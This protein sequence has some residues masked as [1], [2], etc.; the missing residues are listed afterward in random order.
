MGASPDRFLSLAEETRAIIPLGAWVLREACQK[1]THWPSHI[2]I[3]VNLSPL[4]FE[5]GH[6]IE[7][8]MSA[9]TLAGLQ[10]ERLELEVTEMTPLKD[11]AS[12]VRQLK[13]LK[14]LGIKVAMDDFGTGFS[15]LSY[16]QTRV[17]AIGDPTCVV[18]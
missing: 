6:L 14:S 10:N 13:E 15:P 3:A 1:A 5:G 9:L 4:Q 18:D 2:R 17:A 16:L 12:T 7:H 11:N 8:V